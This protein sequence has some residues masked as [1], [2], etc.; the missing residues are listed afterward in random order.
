MGW[1]ADAAAQRRV[2]QRRRRRHAAE[3]AQPR[4]LTRAFA[5]CH[6]LYFWAMSRAE[7]P[8]TTVYTCCS[9]A[10]E[11]G[12]RRRGRD[13]AARG[14]GRPANAPCDA[15]RAHLNLPI[16]PSKAAPACPA[17]G[18][19]PVLWHRA[20]QYHAHLAVGQVV[21]VEVAALGLVPAG[22]QA[23]PS[24]GLGLGLQAMGQ[25]VSSLMRPDGPQP[26]AC[27]AAALARRGAVHI[28]KKQASK[29]ALPWLQPKRRGEG[30]RRAPARSA[31]APL[32]SRGG[33]RTGLPRAGCSRR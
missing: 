27:T 7:S 14:R 1:A 25:E 11:S 24:G 13:A 6:T 5:L 29:Q 32:T 4:Q 33:A 31:A 16:P 3:E 17:A 26:R 10:G 8:A 2:L 12:R 19:M 15:L 30:R 20:A 23:V 28:E 21:V 18:C 9:R 22:G